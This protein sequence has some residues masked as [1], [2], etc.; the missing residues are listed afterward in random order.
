MFLKRNSGSVFTV[1][2]EIIN[3]SINVY[4]YSRLWYYK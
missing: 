1:H 3:N 2:N 4:K